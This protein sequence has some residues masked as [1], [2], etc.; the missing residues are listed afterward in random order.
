VADTLG[1][2]EE[3]RQLAK[4]LGYHVREET[5]GDLPGGPCTVAGV[6]HVLLNLEHT[7]AERLD[8][9][10]A[11]IAGDPRFAAEP[12]SRLLEARLRRFARGEAAD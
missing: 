1:L 4:D 10:L 2:L 7:A 11:A 5:L 6:R 9:L 3:A 8:R 12:K